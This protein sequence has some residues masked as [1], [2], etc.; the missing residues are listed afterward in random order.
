[1]TRTEIRRLALAAFWL[2]VGTGLTAFTFTE[3]AAA[4]PENTRS[5]L[6]TGTYLAFALAAWNGML[7]YLARQSRPVTAADS[8]LP[9]R[10]PLVPKDTE[11]REFEYIP[12]LDFTKPDA[13]EPSGLPPADGRNGD[14]PKPD[15]TDEP[16]GD[17][18][19]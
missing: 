18:R 19:L 6:G 1:M 14:H 4:I 12:E 7:W 5:R 16:K 9:R 8:P 15:G 2:L 3:D 17:R 13:P 11:K 10:K